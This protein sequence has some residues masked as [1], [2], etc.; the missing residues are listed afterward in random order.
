MLSAFFKI[1]CDPRRA[2]VCIQPITSGIP[3]DFK[4]PGS[5]LGTVPNAPITSGIVSVWTLK[6]DRISEESVEYISIFSS[7]L[8]LTLPSYGTQKS[9]I[10]HFFVALSTTITSGL[11][12]SMPLPTRILRFQNISY[13]PSLDLLTELGR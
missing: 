13:K 4:N 8:A 1:L 9:I 3:R 10:V 2:H 12:N 7:S 11:L 6:V 5:L